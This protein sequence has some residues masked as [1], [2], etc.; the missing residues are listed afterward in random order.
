M[1]IIKEFATFLSESEKF[2]A[3]SINKIADI[4]VNDQIFQ[5]GE[6]KTVEK[7]E[8]GEAVLVDKEGKKNRLKQSDL[9]RTVLLLKCNE[10]SSGSKNIH[11]LDDIVLAIEH[12]Y[13]NLKI[14]KNKGTFLGLK[15]PEKDGYVSA[16]GS[17]KYIIATY[18]VSDY[19]RYNGEKTG[20]IWL[21]GD[22]TR[23]EEFESIESLERILKK[24]FKQ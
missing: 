20:V 8:N 22:S 24:F 17:K 1:K 21:N 13:P 2:T 9:D 3:R 16:E 11:S 18:T 15:F 5:L 4:K 6:W 10:S 23:G 14:Q 19:P 12:L 7:I